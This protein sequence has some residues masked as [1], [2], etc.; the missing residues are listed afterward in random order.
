MAEHRSI[1]PDSPGTS[2]RVRMAPSPTGDAHIG[3]ARTTLFNYLF[4]RHYG[5]AFILR[6]DDTDRRREKPGAADALYRDL[7]RLGLD[8]DEGPDI[9]GPS[10][11]YVQSVRTSIYGEYLDR[12][13]ASGHAYRCYCD[14]ARLA[15]LKADQV[16]RGEPPRYDRRCLALAER[17]RAGRERAGLDHAGTPYVVRLCLPAESGAYH[18]LVYGDRRYDLRHADDPILTR[19]D[20]SLLYD[21][22]SVVDDHLM[23]ITHVLRGDGWLSTTPIHIALF[24]A[25]G[26]EP[27]VFGHL[28]QIVGQDRRKLAKRDGSAALG[29]LLRAG[30]LPEA[31]V[32]F[33]ALLGWSPPDGDEVLTLSELVARFDLRR[34]QRSPAL[35]DT[36]KL[37]WLNGVYTRRL[38]PADLATRCLPYLRTAGLL[39]GTS[40][41]PD[42]SHAE[43]AAAGD[44]DAPDVPDVRL[45]RAVALSQDRLRRLDEAPDLLGFFLRAPDLDRELLLERG[46]AAPEAAA[47]LAAARAALTEAAD[48]TAPTLETMLRELAATH[49]YSTSQLFWLVRVAVTGRR[50]APPLFDV[51]AALGRENVLARLDRA[52]EAPGVVS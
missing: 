27:P 17:E 5:G 21:L 6:L 32:N 11:P 30:Y 24:H 28:P 13:L 41:N 49:G 25:L 1:T 29:G 7:R 38:A 9:G 23:A 51:L 45:E 10:G 26:W 34:V 15:T 39:D 40:A 35:F 4:A 44:V 22:A 31:L 18:D 20:G 46:P 47:L 43:N 3:T 14:S 50:A 52:A 2:I 33:L 48:F 42:V 12:L 16:A 19:S 8:W 36:T 37:D